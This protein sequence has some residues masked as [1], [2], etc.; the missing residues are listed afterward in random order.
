ME[1]NP[2]QTF[3]A[4]FQDITERK[5]WEVAQRRHVDELNHRVKNMLAVVQSIAT[6]TEKG[7]ASTADFVRS[8]RQRLRALAEA[9]DLLTR[10][11]WEGASLGELVTQSLSSLVSDASRLQL[12]GPPLHLPPNTI[13]VLALALHEL[14]TNAIKY[15]ALSTASGGVR[16]RWQV[17]RQA[18]GD[19]HVTLEWIESGGPRVDPPERSGFG[20]R[21]L[22]EAITMELNGQTKLDFRKDGLHCA[23]TFPVTQLPAQASGYGNGSDTHH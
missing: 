14:A 1:K 3:A 20:S 6:Q 5:S 11:H 7:A 8:F 2:R 13:F 15:G 4:L 17:E 22:Q 23:I 12:D 19:D 16:V 21:L 18:G 9:H 10:Q